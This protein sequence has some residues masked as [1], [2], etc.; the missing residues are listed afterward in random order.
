M[1]IIVRLQIQTPR[2]TLLPLATV[3]YFGFRFNIDQALYLWYK[4]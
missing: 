4:L 2:R 1:A 3:T